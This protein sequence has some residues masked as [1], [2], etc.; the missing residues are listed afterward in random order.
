MSSQTLSLVNS[1]VD[2]LISQVKEEILR[3]HGCF[4]RI[5][6]GY[7]HCV[8]PPDS[9]NTYGG[10]VAVPHSFY[11]DVTN[12]QKECTPSEATYQLCTHTDWS[13]QLLAH[14]WLVL[15]GLTSV[16]LKSVMNVNPRGC[17]SAAEILDYCISQNLEFTIAISETSLLV[18]HRNLDSLSPSMLKTSYMPHEPSWLE[19]EINDYRGVADLNQQYLHNMHKILGRENT[20]AFIMEG[21]VLSF[22]AKYYGGSQ[23]VELL[24]VGPSILA[25]HFYKV[26]ALPPSSVDD[27][28]YLLKDPLSRGEEHVVYGYVEHYNSESC[29]LLP[30]DEMLWK[31]FLPY[32]HGWMPEC[33]D[34]LTE[35]LEKINQRTAEVLTETGWKDYIQQYAWEHN[36]MSQ[37][38]VTQDDADY[39]RSLIHSH[40]PVSWKKIKLTDIQI[41]EVFHNLH[42]AY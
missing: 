14:E 40:Y 26:S 38:R 35:I 39:G 41:P 11:Y 5:I 28:L 24:M 29:S 23:V 17:S 32:L 18:F 4:N 34:L 13:T 15:N 8:S 10:G 27:M 37:Y 33:S 7:P 1:S 20:G 42:T 36:L 16:I 22:V 25:H 31:Y 12:W 6:P 21:G 9:S 19:P 3:P 2:S 30:T